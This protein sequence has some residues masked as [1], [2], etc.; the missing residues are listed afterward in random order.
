MKR[1]LILFG[2]P[3][4]V[5]GANTAAGH[6]AL[7]WRK[8]DLNVTILP[9]SKEAESNPWTARLAEAGCKIMPP[10]ERNH[11]PPWLRNAIIVD[12]AVELCV[13]LWPELYKRGC[14]LVHVPT[15]CVTLGH[16]HA[17]FALC[18]PTVLVCET[19]FQKRTIGM[20]YAAYGVQQQPIIRDAFDPEDFSFQPC[21]RKNGHFVVGVLARDVPAKWPHRLVKVLEAVRKRGVKLHGHFMGWT[22]AMARWSGTLPTWIGHSA[23][24]SIPVSSFMADLHCLLCLPDTDENWPRVTMEAMAS[25]VPVVAD[26]RAGFKEQLQNGETALLAGSDEES[27]DAICRLAED[28]ELRQRLIVRGR[29]VLEQIANPALIG[30]QWKDLFCSLNCP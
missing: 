18:P 19:E 1:Q 7:L 9:A 13:R 27:A 8:M 21:P 2:C 20:Q 17:T 29:A 24:G 25:G 14:K 23:P 5:G 10:V 16:E 4:P 12:F 15:H 11:L 28:E 6:T 30:A 22:P 3:R 26:N